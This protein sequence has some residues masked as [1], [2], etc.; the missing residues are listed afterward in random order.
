MESNQNMIGVDNTKGAAVNAGGTFGTGN[1]PKT[2][3]APESPNNMMAQGISEKKKS[4]KGML[5]GMILLV[6]V[7]IGG[8]G[9]GVWAMVDGN[10]QK[11]SLNSQI[12]A[13]KE[14]NNEL[15]DKN[16]ELAKK[17]DELSDRVVEL[18][19]APDTTTQNTNGDIN[20]KTKEAQETNPSEEKTKG[21]YS[22]ISIGQCIFDASATP[23]QGVYILKCEAETSLGKGKFVW[24]SERNNLFFAM[25]STNQ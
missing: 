16:S 14:Q 6:L 8:I 7:A 23:G 5:I 17:N 1:T 19:S 13:L 22:V 4:G 10:S 3:N 9:F 11:D 20:G 24:D 15:L 18:E 2:D 25:P 21:E 12:S